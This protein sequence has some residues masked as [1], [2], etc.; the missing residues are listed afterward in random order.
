MY[1]SIQPITYLYRLSLVLFHLLICILHHLQFRYIH[2]QAVAIQFRFQDRS[3]PDHL[4]LPDGRS[5]YICSRTLQYLKVQGSR[6]RILQECRT[7][8]Y[9]LL[10]IQHRTI[11]HMSQNCF[12]SLQLHRIRYLL[13]L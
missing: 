10:L 5:L 6:E 2:L 12:L 7:V 3:K 13:L 4:H 8:F 1:P 9:F 11:C